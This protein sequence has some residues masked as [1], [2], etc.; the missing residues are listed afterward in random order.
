MISIWEVEFRSIGRPLIYWGI[1][2]LYTLIED[3]RDGYFSDL[4]GE[5]KVNWYLVGLQVSQQLSGDS[6][7]FSWGSGNLTGEKNFVSDR[8]EM[9]NF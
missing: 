3:K 1:Y 4:S 9:G 2:F 8:L 7:N 6:G 5:D